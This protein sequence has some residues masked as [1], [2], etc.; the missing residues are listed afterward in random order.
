MVM[1]RAEK[2]GLFFGFPHCHTEAGGDPHLRPAGPGWPLP[3]PKFNP[4]GSV[5]NCQGEDLARRRSGT[6]H[7]VCGGISQ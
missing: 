4:E 6:V 2:P 7:C 3:D 1:T 5:L